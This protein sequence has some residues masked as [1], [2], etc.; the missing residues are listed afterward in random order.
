[1]SPPA[2]PPTNARSEVPTVDV[3]PDDKFDLDEEPS[4]VDAVVGKA[5]EMT[6]NAAEA[7][8][9]IAEA[10]KPELGSTLHEVSGSSRRHT[11][12]SMEVCGEC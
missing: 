8:K 12:A 3:V 1:M 6:V 9:Q 11:S 10:N 5:A 4:M 2:T 7:H